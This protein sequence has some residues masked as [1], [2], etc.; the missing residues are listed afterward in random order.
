[1]LALA[2][3]DVDFEGLPGMETDQ[4]IKE[5]TKITGIGVWTAEIY[6]KF[7][8]GRADAFAAGDLAL[9]EGARMLYDLENRPTDKELRTLAEP[10]RPWRSVAARI[11]WAYY[12]QEKKREGI[13]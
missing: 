9:Q 10:W 5:L 12:A 3:S 13:A 2:R 4:V 6:A 1:A 8:L 7:S 11:L